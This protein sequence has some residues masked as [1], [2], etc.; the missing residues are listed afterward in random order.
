MS[1]NLCPPAPSGSDA[2]VTALHFAM[3]TTSEPKDQVEHREHDDIKPTEV[4]ID[5]AVRGQATTGYETL[6][7]WQTLTTFK[8]SSAI[9]FAA[10]FSAATDGYQIG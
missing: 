6:T 7:F 1:S 4:A 5:A 9:C 2:L 3:A 10:A 8:L